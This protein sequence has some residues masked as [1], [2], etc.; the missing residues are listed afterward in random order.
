MKKILIS[1]LIISNLSF[2]Q[3]A[4][5]LNK[6][7]AA[8][9]KGALVKEETLDS[10]VKSDKKVIKL[11]QLRLTQEQMTNYYKKEA[12]MSREQ[13]HIE[14]TRSDLKSIGS[15]IL[16]CVLTGLAAKVAIESSR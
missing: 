7:E 11:E 14:R 12:E 9:F 3:N 16:G 6:G 4:V 13:A 8:P 1:L 2:A 10:L 15:F 5:I